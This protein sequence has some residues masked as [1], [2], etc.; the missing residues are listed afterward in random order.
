[1]KKSFLISLIGIFAIVLVLSACSKGSEP[2]NS[3]EPT[4]APTAASTKQPTSEQTPSE[5]PADETSQYPPLPEEE[6]KDISGELVVWS[7]WEL[8]SLTTFFNNVYPDVKITNVVMSTDEMHEKLKTVLASG[9][10]LPDIAMVDGSQMGQFNTI[11]GLDNLLDE[12]YDLGRYLPYF[13]EASLLKFQSLDGTKQFGVPW[14]TP[15]G[16]TFYRA[17][18]MDAAGFPSD[19]EEFGEYISDKDNFIELAKTLAADKK[20]TYDW[21]T[22]LVSLYTSGIG[23][24]DRELNWQRNTDKFV[25]ALD[26]A[27]E[28]KNEKLVSYVNFWSDEG[29]QAMAG[30]QLTMFYSGDY[31]IWDINGK[32]P[33]T[34][35]KWRVTNL[36]FGA[37]GGMGGATMV[38]PT[39]AK[40]KLAAWE[41]IRLNLLTMDNSNKEAIQW[42]NPPGF[43]PAYDLAETEEKPLEI[44][45]GQKPLMLY[46]SLVENIPPMI[47]TPLDGKAE[48]IWWSML[49]DAIDKNIDSRTALQQI[50][51][52]VERAVSKEKAELKQKL[53]LQ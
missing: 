16:L 24:F 3:P 29:A 53:G 45:G 18:I 15:P 47:S 52:A 6:L 7:F 5:A 22:T 38:I 34:I 44:L 25:E 37:H 43:L 23:F 35:G 11:E 9:K 27:K 17:D 48:E 32:A 49:Q 46:K 12:P 4:A 19:P 20:Y 31:G 51:E 8:A 30:G 10:G 41:Y 28:M 21:D 42:S 33:D 1:M 40:N 39:Q 26:L 2:D 50:E 36:P 13:T 14:T